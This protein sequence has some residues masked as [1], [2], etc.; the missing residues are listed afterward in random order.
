[1]EEGI[2]SEEW[3]K[4]IGVLLISLPDLKIG[5]FT[6]DTEDE[7][8]KKFT[9][10]DKIKC[11]CMHLKLDLKK[12]YSKIF[13]MLVA[14]NIKGRRKYLRATTENEA[15]AT[16]NINVSSGFIK[17]TIKDIS[18]VG[19]S[20]TFEHDPNLKKNELFKDIQIRLQ[21]M[22]LKAEAVVFG[23]RMNGNEKIYV[24]IFTQRIGPDV[25]VKIRKYIQQNLQTKMDNEKIS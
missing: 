16:M 2:S 12:S 8:K 22:L 17:A 20:C 23:S 5:I 19:V 1:V 24:F 7:I 15:M 9:N 3:D 21:S 14:M 4:W 11:G 6:N 13:E 10:Y 25:K 18:V